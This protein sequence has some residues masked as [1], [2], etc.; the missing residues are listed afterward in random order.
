M[1]ANPWPNFNGGLTKLHQSWLLISEVLW[2]S[3]EFNHF[4]HARTTILYNEFGRFNFENTATSPR[5][6]WVHNKSHFVFFPN[7]SVDHTHCRY[8]AC[9]WHHSDHGITLKLGI[10]RDCTYT[11]K[12]SIEQNY[13]SNVNSTTCRM[14]IQKIKAGMKYNFWGNK[15]CKGWLISFILAAL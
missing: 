13:V 9:I 2:H 1:I 8:A 7:T 12:G 6:Q 15:V 4:A 5:G 11:T 3:A 10:L 14:H